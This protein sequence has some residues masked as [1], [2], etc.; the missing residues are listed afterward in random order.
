MQPYFMPPSLLILI[1]L[2]SL[3]THRVGGPILSYSLG[4]GP[5]IPPYI[6]PGLASPVPCFAGAG[7]ATVGAGPVA[8]S[9]GRLSRSER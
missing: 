1:D 4:V 5:P 2:L 6:G 9:C 7:D 8:W 3:K